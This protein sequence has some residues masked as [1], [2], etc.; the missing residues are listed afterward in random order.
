MHAIQTYGETEAWFHSF[1][2]SALDG[3]ECPEPTSLLPGKNPRY[4]VDRRISKPSSRSGGCE[5]VI[6]YTF[7]NSNMYSSGSSVHS[8][9]CVNVVPYSTHQMKPTEFTHKYH[10]SVQHAFLQRGS[11]AVSP[12][13]QLCGMSKNPVI[14]V[15]VGITGQI[16]RSFLARNSVLH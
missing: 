7:R 15:G 12:L 10:V 4:P 14:Y 5:K 2:S 6:S 11:K 8:L 16:D 1:F 3:G 13:S 9:N